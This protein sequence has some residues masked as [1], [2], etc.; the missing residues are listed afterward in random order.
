MSIAKRG[1]EGEEA[2]A[3]VG[4]DRIGELPDDLLHHVLSFL[5]A[6]EAVR[7]CVLARRWR[8]LWRSAAGLRIGCRH[9][10]RGT[11]V[12]DLRKFVDSLFLLRGGLP[13]DTCELKIGDFGS[14]DDV[15]RVNIWFRHAVMCNVQVLKLYVHKK[16][17]AERWLELDDLPLI[18]HHLRTLKLHGVCCLASFLNF[19]SC[20]ALEHL[21]FE[22]C[23]VSLAKKIS[24]ESIKSL[25]II[26]SVFS[27][28]FRIQIYAP[29]LVS[30]HL[31][32]L[33]NMNPILESM[34]A[35]AEAF[36]RMTESCR[37][38]CY[39]LWGP[40]EHCECGSCPSSKNIGH[41]GN[42]CV[43]LKGLSEAKSLVLISEPEMFIFKRDLRWCP[44]FSKLKTLLLNDYWCMSNDLREL[45]CLLEHSP[46]L[47]KLALQLFSEGPK[48][49]IEMKGTFNSMERPVAISE[50]LK[51]VEIKCKVID[52]RAFKVLKFLCTFNIKAS[53]AD[54]RREENLAVHGFAVCYCSETQG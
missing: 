43:L 6:E 30:L 52:E 53:A 44:M 29:N 13:L 19:S 4:G 35:L 26:D 27:D 2:P 47:E 50:H 3:Q 15:P 16:E 22:Y 33:S 42:S 41:G 9:A 20:P 32:V 48:H 25:K 54:C 39:N 8:H 24:S 31:D 18:S 45:A 51:I 34:P 21:K 5:P 11:C 12:S 37:D 14:H 28:D 17:Y 46:V 38:R 49:K 36:V 23:D 7:T 10:Y 1:E 40:N